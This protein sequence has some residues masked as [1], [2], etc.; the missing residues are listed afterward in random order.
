MSES[1]FRL[2][3]FGDLVRS[4]RADGWENAFTGLGTSR[5]KNTRGTFCRDYR[6][7][8][9]QLRDLYHHHDLVKRIVNTRPREMFREG[10]KVDVKDDTD[11]AKDIN[12]ALR[13]AGIRRLFREGKTWG[14]LYGGCLLIGGIDDGRDMAEPLEEDAPIRSVQYLLLLDKRYVYPA[15]YYEEPN[16]PKYLQVETYG[17]QTPNGHVLDSRIHE[18][19]TVRFGGALTDDTERRANN[20]WDYSIVQH[21][22]NIIR[23]SE[24]NWQSANHLLSDASQAVFKIKGLMAS[25]MTPKGQEVMNT[26]MQLVEMCRSVARAVLLDADGGEEFKREPTTFAG[27]ADMLDRD[28]MRTASAAE[29]PV[30]ILYGRSAAGMNATGDLDFRWFYDSIRSEQTQDVDG[31]LRT[32]ID[33]ILR[34]Q[35]GPTMGEIPE[36]YEICFPRL[37]QPSPVEQAQIKKLVAETD[38]CR[39]DSQVWLPEEVALSRARGGDDAE[40]EIDEELREMTL[41]NEKELA[42]N[43]PPEI[44]DP[45]TGLPTPGGAPATAAPG[46]NLADPKVAAQPAA[47][48]AKRN[49]QKP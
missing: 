2:Q 16:H 38:K 44:I 40:V 37:W 28:M 39:I 32:V 27:I 22:Y 30:A 13:K 1:Y 35:D 23:A 31:E 8:D 26:R 29:T 48:P 11:L 45:I 15:T 6:I 25:L 5:D 14:R 4:F 34:A 12:K 3:Q 43:G 18:T 24:Q 36:E 17:I 46:S 41:E 10:F 20:G 49:P 19:R 47:Q 9:Q 42:K 33:W 21:I 7:T